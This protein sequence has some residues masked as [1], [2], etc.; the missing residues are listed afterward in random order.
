MLVLAFLPYSSMGSGTGT[1][2]DKVRQAVQLTQAKAPQ[3]R[4][5]G[6][7]Q[8]DA[9]LVPSVAQKKLP[10]DEQVAGDANILIFPNLDA[11]N[12]AYKLVQRTTGGSAYGPILQGFAKPISD[13]SRGATVAE[14]IGATIIVS[15]LV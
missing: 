15:S 8:A 11:G 13:L 10:P 4:I 14:I 6:E 3:L 12:I 9:A 1:S 5:V 2:V 7:V